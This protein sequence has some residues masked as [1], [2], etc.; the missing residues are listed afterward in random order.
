MLIELLCAIKDAMNLADI[1]PAIHSINLAP[2]VTE[3]RGHT[4]LSTYP[5]VLAMAG[6]PNIN[7]AQRFYQLATLV[8]GWMPRVLR[9]DQVFA[10]NAINALAISRTVTVANFQS[11]LFQD[12]DNCL[13]SVVG[14]S[15]ILHFSNPAIFP[16]WDSKIQNFRQIPNANMKSIQQYIDY[17]ND[18][19]AIIADPGFPQFFNNF[20]I[21]YNLRLNQSNINQYQITSVRAVEAAAF[22]LAP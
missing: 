7:D 13:H 12:I 19:H 21:A 4:Y 18:V 20:S 17:V 10:N 8:Y 16:I 9:I 11:V 22:E 5:H 6:A 15:K 2:A 3:L 14:A 1:T